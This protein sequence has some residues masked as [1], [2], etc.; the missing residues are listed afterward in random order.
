MDCA[1]LPWDGI[2]ALPSSLFADTSLSLIRLATIPLR[3]P[4]TE[5]A[6]QLVAFMSSFSEAPPGR[7][8][9]LRTLSELLP[10]RALAA[11][12]ACLAA[13]SLL[14][15]RSAELAFF[16]DLGLP[17]ATGRFRGIALARLVAFGGCTVAAAGGWAYSSAFDVMVNLLVRQNAGFRTSIPPMWLE[18]KRHLP[19]N[20]YNLVNFLRII[21]NM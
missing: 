19:R 16:P 3:N 12:L 9:R 1:S 4:Q 2:A 10:S 5:C 20:P 11:G 14:G 15:R 7:L 18:G 6:N 17:R 13:F 8:S 21:P